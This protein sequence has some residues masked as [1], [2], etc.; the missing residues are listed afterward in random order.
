[1][2]PFDQNLAPMPADISS[3][4]DPKTRPDSPPPPYTEQPTNHW[5][6]NPERLRRFLSY[7]LAVDY[8]LET[9]MPDRLRR[10]DW[11]HFMSTSSACYAYWREQ[12]CKSPTMFSTSYLDWPAELSSVRLNRALFTDA[13]KLNLPRPVVVR[14]LCM[15]T[16]C[17][18]V[19]GRHN[20]SWIQHISKYHSMQRLATKPST[21]R[22]LVFDIIYP[23]ADDDT[24]H[25][26]MIA[27]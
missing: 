8:G 25:Q 5:D 11:S 2:A 1:M 13:D 9:V 17:T 20:Q 21:D 6:S 3:P 18:K 10:D 26:Q 24:T 19:L 12:R 14:M 27:H 22:D 16:V 4:P 15:F 23:G 7:C